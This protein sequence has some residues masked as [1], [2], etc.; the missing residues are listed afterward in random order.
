MTPDPIWKVV[1]LLKFFL[2]L[3]A[4]ERAESAALTESFKTS[5]SRCFLQDRW[6][7]TSPPEN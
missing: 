3:L 4:R 5:T 2:V 7:L 1:S 6:N